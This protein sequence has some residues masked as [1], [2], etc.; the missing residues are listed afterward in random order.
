MKKYEFEPISK[1]QHK[2]SRSIDPL[3]PGY[4]DLELIEKDNESSYEGGEPFEENLIRVKQE[5]YQKGYLEAKKELEA[6]AEKEL[7]NIELKK[8]EIFQKIELSLK[9][10]SNKSRQLESE[11]LDNLTFLSYSLVKK[12]MGVDYL[13][14]KKDYIK[15][16]LTELIS[17]ISTK[18]EINITI[19]KSLDKEVKKYLQSAIK[20]SS[21][22]INLI[23]TN[24]SLESDCIIEWKDGKIEINKEKMISELDK[25]F[26]NINIEK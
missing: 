12:I 13:S 7:R 21:L 11:V 24:T 2:F 5:Y 1:I 4:S 16:K 10:I 26:T 18:E 3:T 9:E 14:H 19:A 20:S 23:E 25:V 15:D 6:E 22:T 17:K 8:V